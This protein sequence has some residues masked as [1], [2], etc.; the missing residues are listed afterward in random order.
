MGGR[1]II[2]IRDEN[3]MSYR[4]PNNLIE[5]I[6]AVVAGLALGAALLMAAG[7]LISAAI[8]IGIGTS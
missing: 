1:R 3:Q 7:F 8:L 6:G 2:R 5:L 4:R